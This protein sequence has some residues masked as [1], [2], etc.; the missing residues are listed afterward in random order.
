MND[1]L[2]ITPDTKILEMITEYPVLEE[3]LIRFVPV[4]SKLKNPFLRKTVARVTT[5]RQAAVVGGLSLSDLI[6]SLRKTINQDSIDLCTGITQEVTEKPE[7]IS[8]FNKKYEYDTIE[9]L[10]QGVHPLGK[11]VAET[12]HLADNDYYLLITGFIPQ[13]LIDTLANKG[14]ETYTDK[15]NDTRFGTYIR[16]RL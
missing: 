6:A 9:D 8:I 2:I 15:I 13:P 12:A 1:K 14:F 5:L 16:K 10:N 4:F 11:V 3:E 7:W